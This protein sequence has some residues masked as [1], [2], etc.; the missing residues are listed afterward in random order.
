MKK[1]YNLEELDV[2]LIWELKE[3]EENIVEVGE[4]V[5]VVGVLVVIFGLISEIFYVGLDD[6]YKCYMLIYVI[7]WDV[8]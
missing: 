7:W 1:C 4:I 2:F 5:M 6:C 8:I 3:L